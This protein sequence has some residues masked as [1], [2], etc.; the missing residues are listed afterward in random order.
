MQNQEFEAYK[1]ASKKKIV[2]YINV[3]T[4]DGF[5]S[6]R[7]RVDRVHDQKDSKQFNK[8]WKDFYTEEYLIIKKNQ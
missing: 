1:S 2:E 4:G 8:K 3:D 7:I 6:Y 5:G